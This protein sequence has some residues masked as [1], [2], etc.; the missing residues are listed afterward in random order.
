MSGTPPLSTA[1]EADFGT[2]ELVTEHRVPSRNPYQFWFGCFLAGVGISVLLAFDQP[3]PARYTLLCGILATAAFLM[4]PVAM[5]FCS[6]LFLD[7]ARSVHTFIVVDP[8]ELR[9]WYQEEMKFFEG[10]AGMFAAGFALGA[11]A[12]IAYTVGHYFR[13][14]TVAGAL[15]A[16]ALVFAAAFLAGSS[17]FAMASAARAVHELGQRYGARMVVI[18][19]RFG[20]LS[21][22]RVLAQ[23]WLIISAVWFVYTLSAL[24]GPPYS[25]LQEVLRAYPVV[26]VA[27]P[28][29]P[30]IMG[31]F[32][33]GQMP[34]HTA[35]VEYKRRELERIDA[36]LR[37]VSAT[38]I[39]ALSKE[40]RDAFEFLLKRRN[41]TEALP[42]W[43]FTSKAFAGVST[44]ALTAVLPVLLKGIVP[45]EVVKQLVPLM[46]T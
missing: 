3:N 39:A 31:C 21:T 26:M 30:M 33:Y 25:S 28:T 29:L 43:P 4:I 1:A 14:L 16:G 37:E 18:P 32:L 2:I 9:R 35:M 22:G 34:M 7:W 15:W 11:V 27:A 40:T 6:S 24:F 38:S 44:S 17:L 5:Y 42:E 45:P 23:C 41:E 13:G 10:S 8:D 12:V 46:F 36:L 19:G 20:I